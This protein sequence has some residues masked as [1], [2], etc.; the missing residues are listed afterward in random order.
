[1][2]AD[3]APSAPPS[4]SA[5]AWRRLGALPV[6]LRHLHTR[7]MGVDPG[8]QQLLALRWREHFA[9]EG[10]PL[11]F[12][13]VE[14]R[15]C[16]QNGEDGILLYLFTLLGTAGK[17]CLELCA[18]NGIQC[19]SAN[20]LLHHGYTGVL[21]DG[22]ERQ[23]ALGRRYYASHPDTFTHPP[24][25]V[26][27]WITPD[28]VDGLIRAQGLSGEIDLLS[29]D[30]DGVDYWVWEAIEAVR[31]R[32]VVAEVQIVWGA[33]A[34]VTVPR[35]PGFVAEYADGAGIYCG[36]S[37]PAFVKLARRKGYRLVGAQR[38]GFNAFFVR[39]DLGA[40]VFPEVDAASCLRHPFAQEAKRRWLPRVKDRPWVEV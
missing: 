30:M 34:A 1:M 36:A 7:W 2:S 18:G 12:D 6:R 11:P 9:R 26:N 24:A 20:L 3:P 38:Y 10:R 15:T 4:W 29:L 8:T 17:V 37:L 19:N 13:E 35:D 39:D 27:A 22:D 25:L 32:V 33:E 28:T 21:F 5:R 14:F 16:S 31:P 40:D 23:L